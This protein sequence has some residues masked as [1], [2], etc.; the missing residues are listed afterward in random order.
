VNPGTLFTDVGHF[1]KVGI[2]S[3]RLDSLTV[4]GFVHPGRASRYHHPIN[5][6]VSDIVLNQILARIR[7]HILII[8]GDFDMG[9][10]LSK[11]PDLF[12]IYCRRNVDSTMTDI[13]ADLHNTAYAHSAKR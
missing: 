11:C 9:E 13:N 3:C 10:G 7:A 4:S 1:K 6:I 12:D 5:A 2:E 8:S